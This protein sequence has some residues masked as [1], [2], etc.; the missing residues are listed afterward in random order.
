MKQK[1][2][3]GDDKNLQAEVASAHLYMGDWC[4]KDESGLKDH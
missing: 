4:W 2:M 1:K 3:G